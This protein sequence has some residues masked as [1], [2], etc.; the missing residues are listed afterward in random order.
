MIRGR[1]TFQVIGSAPNQFEM[2]GSEWWL[3]NMLR[4]VSKHKGQLAWFES[5]GAP[6]V[7]RSL[8]ALNCYLRTQAI[9]FFNSNRWDHQSELLGGPE[10]RRFAKMLNLKFDGRGTTQRSTVNSQA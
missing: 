6:L 10:W 8:A 1:F 7:P 5:Y 3:F 4:D 9:R 2:A